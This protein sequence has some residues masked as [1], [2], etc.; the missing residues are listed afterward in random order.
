MSSHVV[1]ALIVLPM[2]PFSSPTH[3]HRC[4]LAPHLAGSALNWAIMAG[5][6]PFELAI[7]HIHVE[8]NQGSE[9]K[10][11]DPVYTQIAMR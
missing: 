9:L 2:V 5:G 4:P 3:T 7:T 8:K 1:E 6:K 11:N 10:S